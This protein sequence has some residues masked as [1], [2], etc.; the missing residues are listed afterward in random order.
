MREPKPLDNAEREQAAR[1]ANR[2]HQLVLTSLI[3][4][5]VLF[6]GRFFIMLPVPEANN[7]VIFLIHAIPLVLFLPGLLKRHPRTYAWLCFIVLFY[8]CQGAVGAFALPSLFGIFALAEAVL[9]STLFLGAMY[10][11]RYRGMVLYRPLAQA[12]AEKP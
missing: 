2:H 10:A 5:L 9:A 8:F 4:L 12:A 3:L 6:A 7:L 11:A 1:R